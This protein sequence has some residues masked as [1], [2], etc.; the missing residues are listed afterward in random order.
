MTM[1]YNPKISVGA[2]QKKRTLAN[3]QFFLIALLLIVPSATVYGM[4]SQQIA[5]KTTPTASLP[6]STATFISSTA[7]PTPAAEKTYTKQIP[8]RFGETLAGNLSPD[9][10]TVI[11]RFSVEE[12]GI[13][14]LY[15][16]SGEIDGLQVAYANAYASGGGALGELSQF[17]PSSK[18]PS[19]LRGRFKV[20]KGNTLLV[21]VSSI[22]QPVSGRF[23]LKS[24]LLPDI[25]TTSIYSGELRIEGFLDAATP[26]RVYSFEARKGECLTA[27]VI[28]ADGL[29]TA[30]KLFNYQQ[31]FYM[32]DDNGG[33]ALNPVLNGVSLPSRDTYYLSVYLGEASVEADR[34]SFTLIVN[35]SDGA[36][37]CGK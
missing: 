31:D 20:Q 19:Q 29:D 26:E 37:G 24:T 35:R 11:Y 22:R 3:A 36:L 30:L 32:Q 14:E 16:E 13:V 1:K 4:N 18:L 33:T 28:S 34:G 5:L 21:Y 23:T 15:A 25:P 2:P 17:Q 6:S 8:T 12:Q 27:Q 9:I 10:R 7:Q